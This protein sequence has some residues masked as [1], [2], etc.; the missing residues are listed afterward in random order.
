MMAVAEAERADL[1]SQTAFGQQQSLLEIYS[2]MVKS[3]NEGVN[4]VIYMDPSV[5]TN[6][7]FA[8]ASLDGL[9]RDL[10]SLSKLGVAVGE[11]TESGVHAETVN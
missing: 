4:K 9:K 2:D 10:Q 8:T 11:V 6:S 3:S 7:P 5:N 1:L